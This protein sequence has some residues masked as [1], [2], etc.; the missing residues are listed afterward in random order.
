MT[1]EFSRPFR[2]PLLLRLKLIHTLLKICERFI[3]PAGISLS[4]GFV[5]SAGRSRRLKQHFTFGPRSRRVLQ[6]P[7]KRPRHFWIKLTLSL[8]PEMV[9]AKPGRG[10]FA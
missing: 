7:W 8:H 3:K 2:S 9:L 5:Q 10:I 1:L 6:A 4:M